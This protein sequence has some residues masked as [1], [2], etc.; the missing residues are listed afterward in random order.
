MEGGM[1][2]R[3]VTIDEDC[4]GESVSNKR[5]AEEG[6]SKKRVKLNQDE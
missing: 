2:P 1:G 5:K 3:V 6:G 4:V